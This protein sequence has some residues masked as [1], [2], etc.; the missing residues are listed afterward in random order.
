MTQTYSNYFGEFLD[1]LLKFN[2]SLI[3]VA[4]VTR[5]V[6]ELA[7]PMWLIAGFLVVLMADIYVA[8]YVKLASIDPQAKLQR[9]MMTAV[10]YKLLFSQQL[11]FVYLP[12]LLAFAPQFILA[13]L[14]VLLSVYA[15]RAVARFITCSKLIDKSPQASGQPE[16]NI[17]KHHIRAA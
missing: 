15:I 1:G 16:T 2:L 7:L 14:I 9:N 6:T 3:F 11:Y 5:V 13:Y 10:T 12:I 8:F 17:R 4:T